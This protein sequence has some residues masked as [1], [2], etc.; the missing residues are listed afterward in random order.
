MDCVGI[1]YSVFDFGRCIHFGCIHFGC[2]HFGCIHF[3]FLGFG[4]VDLSFPNFCYFDC[5]CMIDCCCC[6]HF[7]CCIAVDFGFGT[8]RYC[9]LR[10]GYYCSDLDHIFDSVILDSLNCSDTDCCSYT[11]GWYF[12]GV[13]F[14]FVH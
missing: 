7:G 4:F 3:G 8:D 10:C 6:F 2:I 13:D 1:V 5:C 11:S 12:F 9:L 14:D